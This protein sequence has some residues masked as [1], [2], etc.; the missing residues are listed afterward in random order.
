MAHRILLQ[1]A[2]VCVKVAQAAIDIVHQEED[3]LIE[4]P[5]YLSAWWYNVLFL[6]TS[7][8]VLIAARLS[9]DILNEVPEEKILESWRKA[10]K[11]LE[12]YGAFGTSI[13]RL[14]TTL[15]LLF[16]AVP[17]QYS[18]L[19]Q[20][21]P[22][23]HEDSVTAALTPTRSQAPLMSS[24]IWRPADFPTPSLDQEAADFLCETGGG[25]DETLLDFNNVFDPNDLSWLLTMPFNN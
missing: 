22:R 18:R 24:T 20:Q 2:V 17:Q 4:E 23:Q 15:R 5:Y 13:Q 10:V 21:L 25:L 1:C 8:T 7:A 11:L 14:V 6:Y 9:P 16:D 3:V 19:R 12:K